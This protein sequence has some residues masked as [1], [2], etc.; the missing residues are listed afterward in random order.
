MDL[1]AFRMG[2]ANRKDGGID[3]VF[4]THGLFPMTGAVQIKHHRS[5]AAKVGP[6]DVRGLAGAMSGHPF[7]VGLI[8]TN[9]SFTDDSK[10]QAT[11]VTPPI[12]LRDGDALW[13]WIGDDF[14]IERLE[15]VART[16]E[17]C[18]GIAVRVP[19]FL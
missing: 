15:F 10:H 6:A 18:K 12:Q 1:Q 14:E 7:N 9:T 3:A 2:A 19:Q 4:W 17:F 16:A 8:V 13:K 5:P 11:K